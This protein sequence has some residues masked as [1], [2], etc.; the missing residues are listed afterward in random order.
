MGMFERQ[1]LILYYWVSFKGRDLKEL[2]LT[3]NVDSFSHYVAVVSIGE[4]GYQ[5]GRWSDRVGDSG[6]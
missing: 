3:L 5:F 1:S 2:L 6:I 4:R